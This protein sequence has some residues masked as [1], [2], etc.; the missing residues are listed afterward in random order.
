MPVDTIFEGKVCESLM[1]YLKKLR[2]E[3]TF[4]N[5]YGQMKE[6]L[7]KDLINNEDFVRWMSKKLDMNLKTFISTE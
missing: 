6:I 3:R 1:N 5:L 7:D 4:S 2:Q